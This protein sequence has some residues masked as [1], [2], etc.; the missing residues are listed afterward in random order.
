MLETLTI[1]LLFA[2]AWA[3]SRL[4]AF[5]A[6]W[7]LAWHDRRHHAPTGD[8]GAKIIELTNS[9]PELTGGVHVISVGPSGTLRE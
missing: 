1:L 2:A 7:A 5:I 4:A 6:R 8:L 3:V 9:S